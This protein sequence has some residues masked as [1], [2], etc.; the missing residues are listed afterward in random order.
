MLI[1]AA[2]TRVTRRQGT[3]GDVCARHL[4][5]C[6]ANFDGQGI[7]VGTKREPQPTAYKGETPDA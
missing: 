1:A 7:V 4:W 6:Q 5:E 3:R 2:H